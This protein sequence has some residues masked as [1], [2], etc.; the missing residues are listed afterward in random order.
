MRGPG[1]LRRR[2]P[3]PGEEVKRNMAFVQTCELG[4]CPYSD[5]YPLQ[6][7]DILTCDDCP[8][9]VYV[10]EMELNTSSGESQPSERLG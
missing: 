10:D 2:G 4:Y 8:H 1:R 3:S 9:S 6:P 5:L 7:S